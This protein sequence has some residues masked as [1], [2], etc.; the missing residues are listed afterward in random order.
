MEG[1]YNRGNSKSPSKSNLESYTSGLGLRLLNSI[2]VAPI[3]NRFGDRT[4]LS[5]FRG[6]EVF[7]F[8]HVRLLD[9]AVSRIGTARS[10]QLIGIHF[11]LSIFFI[12]YV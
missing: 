11:T 3:T 5:R 10:I 1:S 9:N 7:V 6:I 4:P 8:G 12:V 2:F